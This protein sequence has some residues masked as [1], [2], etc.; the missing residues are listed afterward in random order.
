M[1]LKM[2]SIGTSQ[3]PETYSD[4]NQLDELRRQAQKDPHKALSQ[5]AHQFEAI[6]MQMLLK[7]MRQ[8][9][10]AFES[11]D[12]PMNNRYVKNYQQMYDKQLALNLSKNGS[13]GL[14]DLMVQQLDPDSAH[15]TPASQLR[16]GNRAEHFKMPNSTLSA[17]STISKENGKNIAHS[18]IT[19]F[20]IRRFYGESPVAQASAATATASK[21]QQFASD[22]E[23]VKQ[24]MP[25]AQKIAA[26]AGISPLAVVAQAAL[27]TGWG[28][29][30]MDQGP[31]QSSHNLFGIK[32]NRNWDGA[33]T[34]VQTLEFEDGVAKPKREKFKAYASY[35]DSLKDYVALMQ[36]PRYQKALQSGSNPHA[37][38]DQLQQAGYATDPNYATKIKRI[39]NSG[40]MAEYQD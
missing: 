39:L 33:T 17:D 21:R 5:V 24:L 23:F 7:E 36:T 26:P 13:L 1:D 25:L 35:E 14:A 20:Q 27:E 9:N 2:Q 29:R 4:L 15:I 31:E 28:Q 22:Q 8:S 30:V 3:V 11:S 16:G 37:F 12:S 38:A 40:V 6:F 34:Q 19:D 18:P 10:T 32:A